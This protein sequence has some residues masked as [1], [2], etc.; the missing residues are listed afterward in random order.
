MRGLRDR[1]FLMP[2]RDCDCGVCDGVTISLGVSVMG[3]GV[4]DKEGGC[5]FGGS[6]EGT[7]FDAKRG[8]CNLGVCDG[9]TI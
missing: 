2:R 3:W 4:C 1:G 6:D 9:F 8:L 7:V 5:A